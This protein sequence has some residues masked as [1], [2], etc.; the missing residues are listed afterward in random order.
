MTALAACG[1]IAGLSDSAILRGTSFNMCVGYCTEMLA[2]DGMTLRLTQQSYNAAKYPTRT[3]TQPL[4]QADVDRLLGLVHPAEIM[5]V[6]GVHGCPD[7]ADGG[8][9]SLEVVGADWRKSVTFEHGARM[10]ELQPLLDRVRT[11]RTRFT[12]TR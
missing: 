12:Q 3:R 6:E 8:A 10:P 4:T 11:L 9:E 7:C 5:S 1:D 2:V